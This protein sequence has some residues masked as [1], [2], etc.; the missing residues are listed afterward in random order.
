MDEKEINTT[1]TTTEETPEML[2]ELSNGKGE[3]E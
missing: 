2:E 1:E 3:D